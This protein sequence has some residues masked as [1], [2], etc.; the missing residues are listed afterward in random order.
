[1]IACLTCIGPWAELLMTYLR[2]NAVRFAL[3]GH[4]MIMKLIRYIVREIRYRKRLR[5]LKKRDP[6]NY[7]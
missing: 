5:E 4:S 6:F 3:E 2:W 7:D 1:M